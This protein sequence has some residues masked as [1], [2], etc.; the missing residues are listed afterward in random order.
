[1]KLRTNNT[2]KL[3]WCDKT[4]LQSLR[5][6]ETQIS[7]GPLSSVP[8]SWKSAPSTC[9]DGYAYN[10]NFSQC[11]RHLVINFA[12]FSFHIIVSVH[13][14]LH[15]GIE[16]CDIVFIHKGNVCVL[17]LENNYPND[18]TG[19]ATSAFSL[20]ATFTPIVTQCWVSYSEKVINY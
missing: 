3:C 20:G 12:I 15:G 9:P 13:V 18:I 4:I 16:Y 6:T 1:M 5:E 17:C 7:S 8:I 11:F 14:V 19:W 10:Y 2:N